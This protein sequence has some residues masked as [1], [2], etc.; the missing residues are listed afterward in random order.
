MNDVRNQVLAIIKANATN[1]IVIGELSSAVRSGSSLES[2][3]RNIGAVII[4][5]PTSSKHSK[6]MALHAMADSD[7]IEWIDVDVATAVR[8][9]DDKY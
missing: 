5:T 7:N 2:I 4:Q 3:Y 6:M 8:Y 9:I 1:P